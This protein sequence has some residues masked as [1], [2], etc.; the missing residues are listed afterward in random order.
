VGSG[1]FWVLVSC[2]VLFLVGLT[3]KRRAARRN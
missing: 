1:V 2:A 3:R